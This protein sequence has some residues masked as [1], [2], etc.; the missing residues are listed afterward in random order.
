MLL[1]LFVLATGILLFKLP[2]AIVWR[3][4]ALRGELFEFIFLEDL[5]LDFS[6]LHRILVVVV[7]VEKILIRWN[8]SQF[9]GWLFC[10][11]QIILLINIGNID[12]P[13]FDSHLFDLNIFFLI[14][15]V[16]L[17][18]L[19]PI[20]LINKLLPYAQLINMRM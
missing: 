5:I 10:S 9:G 3:L 13:A 7:C 1:I 6:L 12:L 16:L 14:V 11:F 15:I 8:V 19:L 17:C 4:I 18:L 20:D 2:Y